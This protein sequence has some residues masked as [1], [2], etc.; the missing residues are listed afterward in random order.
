MWFE[1][2]GLQSSNH[3]IETREF[4]YRLVDWQSVLIVIAS[5]SDCARPIDLG[6]SAAIWI[7]WYP[8]R[9]VHRDSAL[10]LSTILSSAQA[11]YERFNVF[12]DQTHRLIE[13]LAI[14]H[15]FQSHMKLDVWMKRDSLPRFSRRPCISLHNR[16]HLTVG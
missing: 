9:I 15:R 12:Q 7:V 14:R 10:A 11:L 1:N 13:F 5:A 16:C 4:R 3:P 2:C 8:T 6:P